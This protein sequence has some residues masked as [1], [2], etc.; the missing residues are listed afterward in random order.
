M[1]FP[2]EMYLE[3]AQHL[4]RDVFCNKFC[5]C[6][7]LEFH[8]SFCSAGVLPCLVIL[9]CMCLALRQSSSSMKSI[10]NATTIMVATLG[11]DGQLQSS[12]CVCVCVCTQARRHRHK[13]RAES[14]RRLH[15]PTGRA[16]RGVSSAKMLSVL[17]P[18]LRIVTYSG[19]LVAISH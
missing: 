16:H 8:E 6:A 19:R 14:T 7:K 5:E 1:L 15:H 11:R 10:A 3:S 18:S 13:H 9:S 2:Q 17:K 12:K 4:S